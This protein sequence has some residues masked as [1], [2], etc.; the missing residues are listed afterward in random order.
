MGDTDLYK[1][2]RKISCV[3]EDFLLL[4]TMPKVVF[5]LGLN[6]HDEQFTFWVIVTGY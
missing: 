3:M 4:V 5:L 6:F 2:L 1:F